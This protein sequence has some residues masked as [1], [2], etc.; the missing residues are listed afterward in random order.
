MQDPQD[1]DLDLEALFHAAADLHGRDREAFVKARCAHDDAL[2]EQL[3]ALL[4]QHD[5]GTKDYLREQV[6]AAAGSGSEPTELPDAIGRYDILEILGEG[7]MGTVYRAVQ[8]KP[9]H[10][11]VALKVI[12]A[13]MDTRRVVK[14]FEAERQTLALMDHPGIARIFDAGMTDSGRPY[15]VMELVNGQ[16]LTRFCDEQRLSIEQRLLLFQRICAAVQHAHH[17]G[18]IHRDLK[19]SNV[20]VAMQDG[21]PQPKIIDFGIARATADPGATQHTH[22]GEVIGTLDYMSPEQAEPGQPRVDNRSDIY[23]LGAMLYEL[24]TGS[25]PFAEDALHQKVLADAQ[26][27]LRDKDVAPPSTQINRLQSRAAEQLAAVVRARNTDARSIQRKLRGDL[28]WII[29]KA[30]EKDPAQR[31]A[32]ASELA[33][34]VARHLRHE[35]VLAGAPSR[36]YRLHKFARRNRLAVAAAGVVA[37]AFLIGG[38]G[39]VLGYVEAKENETRALAS[40]KRAREKAA[41]AERQRQVAQRNL[42]NFTRLSD[43][44]RIQDLVRGRILPGYLPEHLKE[45]DRWLREADE[46]RSRRSQHEA[47]RDRLRAAESELSV[48]DAQQLKNLEHLID[49]LDRFERVCANVARRRTHV[50]ELAKRTLEDARTEWDRAIAAIAERTASPEYGGLTI[51][52]Q[53]GLIPLGPDTDSGLWEF[54]HVG[55]GKVPV[56]NAEGRLEIKGE[57]CIVLVLIPGGEFTMGAR[58]PQSNDA[59]STRN[60]DRYCDPK[61]SPPHRVVLDPF[62]LSKYEITCAQWLR[63]HGAPSGPNDEVGTV[64]WR[65]PLHPL[66]TVTHRLAGMWLAPAGLVL[67]TEAQWE[68]A[69]RAGTGTISWNGNDPAQVARVGNVL[70]RTAIGRSISSDNVPRDSVSRG[71]DDG[72][73]WTAPVGSFPANAF[74]L[75]DVI[76]NVAEH[77]RD[78]LLSYDQPCRAG[79]GLRARPP[80]VADSNS[81]ILRGG[82]CLTE[83]RFARSAY[84]WSYAMRSTLNWFGVRPAR[85]LDR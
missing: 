31:Y 84:R 41:E 62:L 81:R 82:S 79:D 16:P 2:R 14:R 45:F 30:L 77:V 15:F 83:P 11:E 38:T 50:R 17:K 71:I 5:E 63:L 49:R 64:G 76:G 25:R 52:P 55:S 69:A 18:V 80:G 60:V 23:G 28:D 26:V 29:L 1:H 59:D 43:I 8:Q 42:D 3:L 72:F 32:S 66:D 47:A 85:V 12:K 73:A 46:V 33:A 48:V 34:D 39:T 36:L 58:G 54:A 35:P 4:R 24:L 6:L 74:G 13:G 20:L 65:P 7:G 61:E 57:T 27:I 70:D 75:H 21:R 44:R 37:L 40:E 53:L 68:Y 78:E 56:R 10:R 19:P 51:K 9:V 67:P 22:Q